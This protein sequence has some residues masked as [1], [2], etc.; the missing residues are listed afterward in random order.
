MMYAVWSDALEMILTGVRMLLTCS[1]ETSSLTYLSVSNQMQ[2]CIWL[3][4][5]S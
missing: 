1:I 5:R 2:S 3:Q 4:S